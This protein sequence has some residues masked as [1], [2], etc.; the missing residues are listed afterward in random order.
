MQEV[1]FSSIAYLYKSKFF[2]FPHNSLIML[3]ETTTEKPQVTAAL[4]PSHIM[5]IGM[6][7]QASKLLLTAVKLELFTML[8]PKP[9]SAKEIQ[10]K[11]HLQCT[12][13]HAFDWL[14]ALASLGFLERN[15]LLE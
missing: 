1:Y 6:G 5:Q 14:D 4:N 3:A 8:A 2:N 7:F 13:R 11:L 10:E 9:L 15:G 12:T